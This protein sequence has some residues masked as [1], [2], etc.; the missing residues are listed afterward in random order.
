MTFC[1][2]T[3]QQFTFILFYA[4]VKMS[5]QFRSL[6]TLITLKN[7]SFFFCLIYLR[8]NQYLIANNMI[9][10]PLTLCVFVCVCVFVSL[11]QIIYIWQSHSQS[12][13]K[14]KVCFF[15][16][17]C[18]M[19][20]NDMYRFFCFDK[21][22]DY[23]FKLNSYR[24]KMRDKLTKQLP[25]LQTSNFNLFFQFNVIVFCYDTDCQDFSK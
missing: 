13:Q 20:V 5:W 15:D 9:F 1:F 17:W 24:I 3:W 10:L 25:L 6:D 19:P 16:F 11:A 4:K 7:T 23:F 12:F 21:R 22:I 14:A 8:T 2:P 18:L